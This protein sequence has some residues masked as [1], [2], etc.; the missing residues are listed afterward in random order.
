MI[1]M[2]LVLI[3]LCLIIPARL[4]GFLMI[5]GVAHHCMREDETSVPPASPPA[6]AQA[7]K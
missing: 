4:V 2:L 3:L 5:L 1:T 6:A 7:F